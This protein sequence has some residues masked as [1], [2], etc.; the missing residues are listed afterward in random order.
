MAARSRARAEASW[1]PAQP[2]PWPDTGDPHL[3]LFRAAVEARL[4]PYGDLVSSPG[5]SVSTYQLSLLERGR[6][7]G[8]DDREVGAFLSANLMCGGNTVYRRRGIAPEPVGY[9]TF[10]GRWGAPDVMG[11]REFWWH[12]TVAQGRGNVPGDPVVV[13]EAASLCAAFRAAFGVPSRA[14]PDTAAPPRF[15]DGQALLF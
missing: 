7:E 6:A 8:M 11:R 14:T 12:L 15:E 1:S 10:A 13:W 3:D 4:Y 5:R 9:V 2:V